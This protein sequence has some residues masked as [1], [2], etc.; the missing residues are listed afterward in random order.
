MSS[1]CGGKLF[2][3]TS[4][5]T[6][7]DVDIAFFGREAD[8]ALDPTGPTL[9]AMHEREFGNDGRWGKPTFDARTN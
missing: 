2:G 6:E 3:H 7:K 5:E 4:Q 9:V 1:G 8:G